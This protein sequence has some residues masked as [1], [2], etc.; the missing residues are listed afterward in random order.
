M[1]NRVNIFDLIFPVG[2]VYTSVTETPP[3]HISEL[4]TWETIDLGLTGV[5]S[6]KRIE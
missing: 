6:W 2:M 3:E 1:L 5:Y 4:G